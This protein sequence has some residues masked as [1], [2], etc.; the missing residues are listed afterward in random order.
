[1]SPSPSGTAS[2]NSVPTQ[3]RPSPDG[4]KALQDAIHVRYLGRYYDSEAQFKSLPANI[5]KQISVLNE[6]A[7]SYVFQGNFRKLLGLFR[8]PDI[9]EIESKDD[10]LSK[11]LLD[12]SRMHTDLMLAEAVETAS[13]VWDKWLANRNIEEYDDVDVCPQLNTIV[14]FC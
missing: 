13:N 1:M 11:L 9:L 4:Q 12:Y 5:G 6:L 10:S 7:I 8:E 2:L 3:N 14:D